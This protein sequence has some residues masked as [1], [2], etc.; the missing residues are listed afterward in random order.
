MKHL[1]Y[2]ATPIIYSKFL[3]EITGASIY[4]KRE[5]LFAKGGGGSKARMLQYILADATEQQAEYILTAGGPYSNF[6][7]ALALMCKQL[8]LKIR[9]VL[10]DKNQ[11]IGKASLNKRICDFCEVEYVYCEP[12]EVVETIEQQKKSLEKEGE[13]FYYIWGGGKSIE[14]V[15]AYADCVK[16]IKEQINFIPDFIFTALGTG[17]TF[18]GLT[19]GCNQHLPKTEVV[20]ISVARKSELAYQAIRSI[21]SEF[22]G[23]NPLYANIECLIK[24]ENIIDSYLQGGYGLVEEKC[25]EFIKE[26]IYAEAAIFD[27][28]YVGKAL[29]GLKEL[30]ENSQQ[31]KGKNI[32]FMNTGGVFNF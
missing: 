26:A 13:N 24:Q 27:E 15:Y 31:F 12:N 32:I 17:T 23:I 11:H 20:G 30:C 7:R 22:S 9:L 16:E 25:T 4:L 3:S 29:F 5:D 8:G 2:I 19:I 10:Y 14:G 18:S 1:P 6:N 28:I 21:F